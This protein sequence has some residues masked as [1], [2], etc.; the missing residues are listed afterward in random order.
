MKKLAELFA[1]FFKM[2]LFTFGGGL[3]MLPLIQ[4]TIVTDKGWMNEEEM[5]D[6][7]AVSQ[8]MPGVIAVNAATYI[9]AQR[10]GFLGALAATLGVI[11]PSFIII[12][13]AVLFLGAIGDNSYVD[14]AF[15]GIKA[16]SCALILYAAYTLGKQVLK[17]KFE[18][19]IAAAAF[20]AIVIFDVTALWAIVA[21]AILGVIRQAYKSRAM[22]EGGG[23]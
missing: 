23:K 12:I 22:K 9:G 14:G 8:S 10:K 21:G 20:A 13:L 1:V 4:R 11:M 15:T 16:A 7:V 2:G 17:G 3:A 6:C 18:W 19:I 5:I